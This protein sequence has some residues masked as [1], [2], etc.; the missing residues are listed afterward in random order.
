M[1][2][3]IILQSDVLMSGTLLSV[4]WLSFWGLC[5]KKT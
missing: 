2:L 5:Y 1:A 4:V 3:I